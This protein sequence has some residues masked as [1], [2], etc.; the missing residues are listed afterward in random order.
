MRFVN[1]LLGWLFSIGFLAAAVASALYYPLLAVPCLLAALT[2]FPP[3][4]AALKKKTGWALSAKAKAYIIPMLIV[5]WLILLAIAQHEERVAQEHALYQQRVRF[6]SNNETA[7]LD[8]I[9]TLVSSGQPNMALAKIDQYLEFADSQ[10]AEVRADIVVLLEHEKKQARKEAILKEL[11]D[12]PVAEYSR[13]KA[14]YGELLEIEPENAEFNR[15]YDFY[16]KKIQDQMIEAA[17]AAA[18]KDRIEGQFS[19]WD[20]AHSNLKSFIKDSMND[21]GSF[22]HVETVYW[23]KGNYLIVQ[24]TFRGKNAFGAYVMNSVRARV[25]L[26]GNILEIIEWGM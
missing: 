10:L 16:S 11:R 7:I 9:N 19:L 3:I 1:I 8:S 17:R 12:I 25:D 2:I 20:G 21:P 26:D 23:D 14:L 22:K 5:A 15:K 24:T 4:H 6:Y 18:R 13:N